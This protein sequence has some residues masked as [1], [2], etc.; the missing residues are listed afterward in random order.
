[1][2][3]T[4]NALQKFLSTIFTLQLKSLHMYATDIHAYH[5]S[6]IRSEFYNKLIFPDLKDFT[7]K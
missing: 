3:L 6:N 1:M 4:V 7:I 2:H 5:S